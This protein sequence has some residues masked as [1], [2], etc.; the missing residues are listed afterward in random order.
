MDID[1]DEE[2]IRSSRRESPLVNKKRQAETLIARGALPSLKRRKGDFNAAY[3]SLLNQDIQ[4]AASGLIKNE[5]EHYDSDSESAPTQI[6]AVVWSGAE[7]NAFFAA[8]SRLGR[9]DVARI[10][11]RIGTKS[12]LEVQQYLVFLDA[13]KRPPRGSEGKAGAPP[14]PASL[15][16]VGIPAAVEIGAECAASLEAVA[17]A[18]ALRQEAHEEEV[19]RERWGARWL[20]TSP[21]ATILEMTLRRHNERQGRDEQVQ[22]SEI[23]MA[24]R[25]EWDDQPRLKK[26]LRIKREQEGEDDVEEGEWDR[27]LEEMPFLQLFHVENWLQLSDR[28]FMNS[29]IADGNWRA[30]A[31]EDKLPAIQ[32][33]ALA[34]FHALALSVT[35]RLI[36]AAAYVAE[37]RTRTRSLDDARRNLRPRIRDEDVRAAVSSLG[38]RHNAKEF[39]ARCA[40]RLQLNVVDDGIEED[41]DDHDEDREGQDNDDGEEDLDIDEQMSTADASDINTD[42]AGQEEEGSEEDEDYDIM[43]YDAVEAALGFQ[44]VG[45]DSGINSCPGSHETDDV[46]PS[47]RDPS[48][49]SSYE[50]D[51]REDEDED[52]EDYIQEVKEQADDDGLNLESIDR[53]VEEAM[54]STGSQHYPD[55]IA[56]MRSRIRAEHRLERDAEYLDIKTSVDAEALLWAILRGETDMRKK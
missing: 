52:D 37:S 50:S 13:A 6:G 49:S 11:V 44:T 19:E 15:Q 26:Q 34:D 22:D 17:D 45:I 38:M 23:T 18:L 8:V 40:R 47:P 36:F 10:A 48:S 4:D 16:P 29:T 9:D 1:S 46:F 53:D 28:L 32:A 21:L 30:V 31:E 55:S 41:D 7:K 2:I 54:A 56:A 39:W 35:R 3:L 20:I 27:S 12:E 42:D 51:P 25:R 24:N 14:Q 5:E 33:T 43:S